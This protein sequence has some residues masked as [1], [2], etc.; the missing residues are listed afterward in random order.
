MTLGFVLHGIVWV[1]DLEL[2]C[3]EEQVIH[4]VIPFLASWLRHL[5][6]LKYSQFGVI[7]PLFVVI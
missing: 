6:G 2:R 1:A 3:V 5:R 7:G 4:F